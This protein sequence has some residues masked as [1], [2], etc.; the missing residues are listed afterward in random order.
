M[1]EYSINTIEETEE[2]DT[3]EIEFIDKRNERKEEK[4]KEIRIREEILENVNFFFLSKIS[5]INPKNQRK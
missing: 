5:K 4:K 2:N 1:K 3:S